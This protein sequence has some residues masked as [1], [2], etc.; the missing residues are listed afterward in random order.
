MMLSQYTRRSNPHNHSVMSEFA[1]QTHRSTSSDP[2]NRSF[3]DEHRNMV[4]SIKSVFAAK[5]ETIHKT[6]QG[7]DLTKY[8][9]KVNEWK[10][11]HNQHNQHQTAAPFTTRLAYTGAGGLSSSQHH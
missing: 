2:Y 6:V 3:E 11:D 9:D 8:I 10:S 7:L 5:L 4:E 1:G